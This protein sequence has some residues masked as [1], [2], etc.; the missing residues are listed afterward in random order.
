MFRLN[1]EF[2]IDTSWPVKKDGFLEGPARPQGNWFFFDE[3]PRK[4]LFQ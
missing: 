2:V 3:G 1:G 4:L